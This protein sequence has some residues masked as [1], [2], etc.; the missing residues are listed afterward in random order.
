[1]E[2]TYFLFLLT[3][4]GFSVLGFVIA[5][6][7]KLNLLLKHKIFILSFFSIHNLLFYFGL[8]IEGDYIDYVIFAI[9]YFTFCWAVFSLNGQLNIWIKILR[10]IGIAVVLLGYITGFI[11]IVLFI[12]I[13]QDYEIDKVFKF[14]SNNKDYETRR[15]TFGFATLSDTRY[16]F[17]TYRIFGI[18][19]IE[20]K[21]DES[22]FFGNKTNLNI[23]ESALK[24]EI[25]H[26]NNEE[27]IK[28]I[29][30][31]GNVF[32]KIIK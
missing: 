31:N 21:I 9:E 28:F 10:R 13:S 22:D 19:P 3:F 24:I 7:V 1:M 25:Y 18:I 26:I 5:R 6:K 29:S 16:T 4:I 17:K 15:Y 30:S 27:Q 32:I 14:T 12:V 8:S 23:G 20:Y 2:F 11:G